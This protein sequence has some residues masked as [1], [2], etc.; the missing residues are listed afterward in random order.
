M[1]FV[2]D[3]SSR[4]WFATN[5]LSPVLNP[6]APMTFFFLR[7]YI[8]GICVAKKKKK[9]KNSITIINNFP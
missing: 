1:I 4:F 9:K 2:F 8:F 6:L 7:Y 5:N 3:I